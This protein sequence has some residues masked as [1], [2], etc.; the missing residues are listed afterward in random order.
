VNPAILGSN[1]NLTDGLRAVCVSRLLGDRTKRN[2]RAERPRPKTNLPTTAES[3][4]AMPTIATPITACGAAN[5]T[6]AMI[7]TG[8]TNAIPRMVLL[9]T[10]NST[11]GQS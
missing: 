10:A 2:Q 7:N 11:W 5:K 9:L 6:A 8:R 1:N 4:A 3:P